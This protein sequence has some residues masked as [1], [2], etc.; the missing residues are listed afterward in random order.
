MAAGD[1]EPAVAGAATETPLEAME[2]TSAG[3]QTVGSTSIDVP[4]GLLARD[5]PQLNDVFGPLGINVVLAR[6]YS[7]LDPVDFAPKVQSGEMTLAQALVDYWR[8]DIMELTNPTQVNL[9]EWLGKHWP[10]QVGEGIT[11]TERDGK[12]GKVGSHIQQLEHETLGMS[13]TV[14][15]AQPQN[16]GNVVVFSSFQGKGRPFDQQ[17]NAL[18]ATVE[19]GGSGTP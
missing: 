1:S 17:I 8:L 7:N 11:L 2:R 13:Q 4:D 9:K 16:G 5:N 10:T 14:Y 19:F 18:L 3:R 15:F 6:T 12:L